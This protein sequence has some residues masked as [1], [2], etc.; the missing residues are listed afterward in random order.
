VGDTNAYRI[1]VATPEEMMSSSRVL[2]EKLIVGQLANKLSAL[3]Q[4]PM[5]H[6]PVHNIPLLVLILCQIN[7]IYTLASCFFYLILTPDKYAYLS[8]FNQ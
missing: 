6:C 1:L 2:L 7:Q 4:N 8:H 5:V 3:V